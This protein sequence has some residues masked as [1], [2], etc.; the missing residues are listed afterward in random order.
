MRRAEKDF[1]LRDDTS[2]KEKLHGYAEE[3]RRY[4]SP[5]A[6][7]DPEVSR[8]LELLDVYVRKFD[9]AFDA[10]LKVSAYLNDLHDD[11]ESIEK[12]LSEF[13][14]MAVQHMDG[15]NVENDRI[16]Q[17]TEL[18]VAIV[19]VVTIAL[20]LLVA[21]IIASQISSGVSQLIDGTQRI[22]SGDLRTKVQVATRDEID[23]MVAIADESLTAVEIEFA[24]EI[25][26]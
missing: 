2:Y 8:T 24:A 4:L 17:T 25:T 14:E 6:A 1:L 23:R 5:L 12:V 20:A 7:N 15:V 21:R 13:E 22:G 11:T 10:E 9:A 26:E 19:F 3:A 18:I 16:R